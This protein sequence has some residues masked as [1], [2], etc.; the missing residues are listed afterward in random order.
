VRRQP[1]KLTQSGAPPSR[2]SSSSLSSSSPSG[3][4]ALCQGERRCRARR[5]C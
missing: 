1:I 2:P 3:W 4:R 5:A